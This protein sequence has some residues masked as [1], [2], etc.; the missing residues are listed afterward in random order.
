MKHRSLALAVRLGLA[1]LL[2]LSLAPAAQADSSQ[3]FGKFYLNL[4]GFLPLDLSTVLSVDAVGLPGRPEIDLEEIL[5]LEN[6]LDQY[7]L[8][9]GYRFNRRNEVTFSLWSASRDRTTTLGKTI[10]V[11][12]IVF[13]VGL[14]VRTEFKTIDAEI[15]YA[16]Y[17]YQSKRGELAFN[18]GVHGIGASF[19]ISGQVDTSLPNG[20][21]VDFAGETF[22]EAEL[23]LP[24]VG[25]NGRAWLTRKL[26]FSGYLRALKAEI[27]GYEGYF[28]DVE[29][30]LEHRT[31][32]HLGFGAAF[33]ASVID[34]DKNILNDAAIAQLRM[35]RDGVLVMI[36]VSI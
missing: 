32:K 20:K 16:Y 28:T 9:G 14:N 25:F 12:D 2:T 27:A 10:E 1:C 35:E 22:E 7:R 18:L 13:D 11:G 6:T 33:Y 4:Q 36:R 26:I 29:L 30:S 34:V 5:D 24:V 3:E 15:A 23:P 19:K 17:F 31:F 8:R 21:P